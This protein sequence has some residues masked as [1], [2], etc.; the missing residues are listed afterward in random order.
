MD[1]YLSTNLLKIKINALMKN[2]VILVLKTKSSNLFLTTLN[3]YM[4]LWGFHRAGHG[5]VPHYGNRFC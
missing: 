2:K 3:I 5:R 1:K 4:S